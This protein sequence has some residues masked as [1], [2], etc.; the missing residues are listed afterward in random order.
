MNP[1]PNQTPT[2]LAVRY[3]LEFVVVVLG[4]TVSFWFNE[5]N[6]HQQEL[7]YQA[8]DAQDL[9]QDLRSDEVRLDKVAQD[10]KSG[11]NNTARIKENHKQLQ[12]GELSY[13]SFADSLIQLGLPYN[14]RTFFMN[15]GTYK[16]L[17]NNGR[18]Q[19][20]PSD[21][22]DAIKGYYEYVSKRVRDNNATVDN[23]SLNYVMTHHPMCLLFEDK[24]ERRQFMRNPRIQDQYESIGFYTGTIAFRHRIWVHGSQIA[25][26]ETI[27]DRVDSMLVEFLADLP[28]P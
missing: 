14:W 11:L 23:V 19:N 6:E 15:D 18:L 5:W 1:F 3:S 20:F 21:L 27:R 8:K 16:T 22:E 2:Y 4:I 28:A 26:Y 13:V 17:L 7:T 24:E 10:T 25:Q 12:Q 9:L